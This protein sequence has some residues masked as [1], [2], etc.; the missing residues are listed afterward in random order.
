MG[1]KP[2]SA[3]QQPRKE[4]FLSSKIF[5]A[6]NFLEGIPTTG[7]GQNFR[8]GL[9][10][11]QDKRLFIVAAIVKLLR[12]WMGVRSYHPNLHFEFTFKSSCIWCV[13]IR[14]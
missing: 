11:T 7:E 10:S 6:H 12:V 14:L 9:C 1:G 13:Q 8:D 2:T 3:M 4:K 5:T